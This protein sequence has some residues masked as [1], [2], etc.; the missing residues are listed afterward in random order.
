MR[1]NR[2]ALR[3]R[4][5]K[6]WYP[7]LPIAEVKAQNRVATT[8]REDQ[9]DSCIAGHKAEQAKRKIELVPFGCLN[10]TIRER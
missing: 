9:K 8:R 3:G 2:G 10:L 4:H 1:G 6:E 7:V 5:D